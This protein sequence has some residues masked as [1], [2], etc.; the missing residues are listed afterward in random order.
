MEQ[1]VTSGR[2]KDAIGAPSLSGVIIN[3]L[4]PALGA[5]VIGLDVSRP[6]PEGGHAFLLDA[7]ET[8]KVLVIRGQALDIPQH[9]IFTGYFGEIVR[10][11]VGKLIDG[12]PLPTVFEITNLDIDGNL[13]KRV[14][15]TG[16]EYWH[17]DGSHLPEP[18]SFT[19]LHAIHLPPVGGD[20]EFANMELAYEALPEARKRQLDGLQAVHSYYEKHLNTGGPPP[21]PEQIRATPPV[22][23]PLVR[24]D[25][26][27]GR[28]SLYLGM[29]AVRIVGMPDDE[30]LALLKE[31]MAHATQRQFI[32]TQVWQPGD[33]LVWDNRSLLHRA[34]GNYDGTRYK[35]VLRRAV[36]KGSVPV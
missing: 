28:K 15:L 23:H 19:V 17:T 13:M 7:I 3:R 18:S 26:R 24:T 33:V 34:M 29:Y 2:S 4:S 14:H 8:H 10:K 20:T 9:E 21:A 30:A 16:T 1:Q 31:L 25:P 32:F 36:V 35:R 5:E 22:T 12:T 11:H 27:S 6:L